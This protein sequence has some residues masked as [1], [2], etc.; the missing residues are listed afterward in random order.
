MPRAKIEVRKEVEVSAYPAGVAE[1][2]VQGSLGSDIGRPSSFDE[3]ISFAMSSGLEC[4][5]SPPVIPMFP[6]GAPGSKPNSFKNSIPIQRMTAGISDGMSGGI[7]R[8]RREIGK[9]RSPRLIARPGHPTSGE[10]VAL[11]FDEEDEDFLLSYRPGQDDNAIS[12]STS[13]DKG[14]SAASIS[15]PSSGPDALDRH[16]KDGGLARVGSR[17]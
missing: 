11:E 12:R 7:G 10:P 14:G 16:D 3:P 6:N 8:L 17:G 1:F 4:P 15:T 5:S 2:F 13:R 9:V